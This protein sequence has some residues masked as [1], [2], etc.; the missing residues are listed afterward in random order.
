MTAMG[1]ADY[2]GPV[3]EAMQAYLIDPHGRHSVPSDR[4]LGSLADLPA[5][6]GIFS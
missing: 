4:R 3:A 2:A 6:L 1:I 5:V